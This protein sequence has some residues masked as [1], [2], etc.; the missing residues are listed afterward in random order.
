[1]RS[2]NKRDIIKDASVIENYLYILVYNYFVCKKKNKQKYIDEE[3]KKNQK[4]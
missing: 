4:I 2:G 3:L 1:M